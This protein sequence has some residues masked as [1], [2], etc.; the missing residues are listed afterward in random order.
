MAVALGPGDPAPDFNLPAG[1]EGS[2]SLAAL[3]GR[4][5]VLY[6][7]PRADTPGCTREAMDFNRLRRAFAEAG[8]EII[9]VSADPE[10]AVDKFRKKHRL[11]IALATDPGLEVLNAYGVWAEKSMYGRK[12]MGIVRTTFLI[13]AKGRIAQVWRNVRVPDHAEAVLAAARALD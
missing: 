11:S 13:D 5:V 2:L 6:F 3:R 9:G 4:K 12:F 8:T 7:Y 1:P 10:T